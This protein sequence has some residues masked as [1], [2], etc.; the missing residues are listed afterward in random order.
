MYFKKSFLVLMTIVDTIEKTSYIGE[1]N[2]YLKK[3]RQ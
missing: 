2:E 3:F 1:I